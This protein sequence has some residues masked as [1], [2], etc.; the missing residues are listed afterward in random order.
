MK[1]T[2]IK[3]LAVVTF[4]LML[5]SSAIA[6]DDADALTL[7]L[8]NNVQKL[9][10]VDAVISKASFAPDKLNRNVLDIN[11]DSTK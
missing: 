1:N 5:G 6:G 2:M 4:G 11:Y 9:A 8:Q 10:T 3:L 7:N